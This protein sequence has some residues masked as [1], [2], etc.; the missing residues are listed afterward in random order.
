MSLKMLALKVRREAL[1]C[2]E[3]IGGFGDEALSEKKLLSIE[4]IRTRFK[5][6]VKNCILRSV[7]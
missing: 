2:S 6:H 1:S 7:S 4:N 3:Q 5:T